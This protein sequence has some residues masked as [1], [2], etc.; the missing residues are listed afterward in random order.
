[1]D[2]QLK[3][4]LHRI[5][6]TVIVYNEEGKYLITR[7]SLAKKVFPGMW[8]VLGGGLNTDDYTNLPPTTVAGQWYNPLENNM[9]R[10]I[11]EEVNIEI[12]KL[13][14]LFDLTFI[15]PDG[16]PIL[17]LSYYAPFIS[18][19]VKY[20]EDT[21]DHAWVTV[22]ELK[23]YELIDGIAEEIVEVDK[24]LKSNEK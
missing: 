5:A 12:G 9:R 7:R 4:E 17:V 20:D 19:D 24:I 23:N 21:I 15:R 16:V 18:G 11:R 13:Q 10:E 3:K 14:Y 1:M 2:E 8:T 6:T 22:E